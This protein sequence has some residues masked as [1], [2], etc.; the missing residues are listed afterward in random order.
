MGT[1]LYLGE[2]GTGNALL[3]G[4]MEHDGPVAK[5]ARRAF[6]ERAIRIDVLCAKGVLRDIAVLAAQI[7]D[8]TSL[9]FRCIAR[10]GFTALVGVQMRERTGAVA[11][12]G[13]GSNMQMVHYCKGEL[14][15]AFWCF[16]YLF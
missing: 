12:G 16:A 8:L 10:R 14:I 15:H 2:I 7:S 5:E 4:E 1:C 13:D 9:G 3:V 6:L 11:I